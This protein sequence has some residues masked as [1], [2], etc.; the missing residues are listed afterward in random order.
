MHVITVLRNYIG[1]SQ[2]RL[3]K[4]AGITQPDLSEM[5]KLEPYGYLDKYIR[6]SKFLGVS[7]DCLLK[8]DFTAIPES[9]FDNHLPQEYRPASSSPEGIMGRE[10]EEYIL[11]REQLRLRDTFPALSKLV[12][13]FYKMKAY[14]PG[15]DILSF[16]DFGKPICLEV[17]TSSSM[18]INCRFSPNEMEKA[19][20]LTEEGEDY[21]VVMLQGWGTEEMW[22]QDVPY[23]QLL[24][25]YRVEPICYSCYP[26]PER[27]KKPM[28][29]ISFFRRLRGLKQSDLAEELGIYPCHF[30]LYETGERRPPVD[31]YLQLSELLDASIDELITSYDSSDFGVL[32]NH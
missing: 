8:N 4:E 22:I 3:S 24:Q 14:W 15:Y 5:E 30:S 29:G 20:K 1:Y 19:R 25:D 16:D 21:R 17:K 11:T 23:C 12:L 7:V 28:S 31:V 27:D 2:M 26:V 6:V 9:F 32:A 10:G 18:Q 13:P